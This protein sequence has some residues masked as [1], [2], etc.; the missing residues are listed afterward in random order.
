MPILTSATRAPVWWG[1]AFFAL[2]FPPLYWLLV[3]PFFLIV[4]RNGQTF[5][6]RLLGM[7][8]IGRDGSVMGWR[9]TLLREVIVKIGLVGTVTVFFL[10]LIEGLT[11]TPAGGPGRGA[12]GALVCLG[13]GQYK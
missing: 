10:L 11:G 5:G 12:G 1:R 8:A 9:Y 7:Y 2:I 6:K 4:A 3:T 13:Q